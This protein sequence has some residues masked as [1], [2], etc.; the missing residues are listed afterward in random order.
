MKRLLLVED[1]LIAADGLRMALE[2]TGYEVKVLHEETGILELIEEWNPSVLIMDVSLPGRDGIDV[3]A[4][5]RTPW[6]RLPIIFTTGRPRVERM[7]LILSQ[8]RTVM[9]LKPFELR[10]L[11]DEIERLSA[12]LESAP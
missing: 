9:L 6:P 5:I 10:S 4:D 1:N 12:D 8:E 11:V 2:F 3:A 7:E